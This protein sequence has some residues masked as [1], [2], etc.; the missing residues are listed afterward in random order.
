MKSL[1]NGLL[2]IHSKG[3]MHRDLTLENVMLSKINSYNQLRIIDF[4]LAAMTNEEN[5]LFKICGTP[6][7]IA[8][9]ILRRKSKTYSEKCDIFSAGVIFYYLL[10]G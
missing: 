7:F 4:G 9:E 6:G 10:T 1:L 2:Y 5:A 3:I 8:P